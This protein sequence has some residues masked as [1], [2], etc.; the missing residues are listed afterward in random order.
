MDLSK[1]LTSP[2]NEKAS[3]KSTKFTQDLLNRRT[4]NIE[5]NGA[6]SELDFHQLE[7]DIH[8]RKKKDQ[9]LKRFDQAILEQSDNFEK[10]L[11]EAISK[12][13]DK[14]QPKE[15]RGRALSKKMLES[16]K[17]QFTPR[18]EDESQNA[19]PKRRKEKRDK[20]TKRTKHT[21]ED[22]ESS[23]AEKKRASTV[24]RKHNQESPRETT[25]SQIPNSS[26]FMGNDDIQKF[27]EHSTERDFTKNNKNVNGITF[28]KGFFNHEKE[29][30]EVAK[31]KTTIDQLNHI[32]Q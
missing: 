10:D 6:K 17:T 9:K 8:K 24:K 2:V 21:E 11:N 27:L 13:Y 19:K 15:L 16:L 1:I 20:S 31:F 14:G 18:N 28:M 12:S 25:D 4:K 26:R 29:N 5:E 3:K 22:A 7:N 23:N 32:S 30:K